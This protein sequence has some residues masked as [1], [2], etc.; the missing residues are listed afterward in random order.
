[1]VIC[2]LSDKIITSDPAG[3]SVFYPANASILTDF[4]QKPKIMKVKYFIK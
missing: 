4:S 2:W 3:T 1:M